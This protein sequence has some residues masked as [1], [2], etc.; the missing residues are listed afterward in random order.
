MPP[1][2]SFCL[3][4]TLFASKLLFLI[5]NYMLCV[6]KSFKYAVRLTWDKSFTTIFFYSFRNF[7]VLKPQFF[8]F[9]WGLRY[10]NK[11][12]VVW[13]KKTQFLFFYRNF[14]SHTAI[15][16][17]KIQKMV[18][19][20]VFKFLCIQIW[21]GYIWQELQLFQSTS[22]AKLWYNRIVN[23]INKIR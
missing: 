19:K 13:V 6:Q 12:I 14:F 4:N 1:K 18:I 15:F 5:P 11:K 9:N 17:L 7:F 10:K 22:S 23:N 16:S 2:Y 21:Y 3:Q 8:I 20:L